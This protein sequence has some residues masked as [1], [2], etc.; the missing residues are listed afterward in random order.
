MKGME[1]I[2]KMEG[3]TIKN[4]MTKSLKNLV[5][6]RDMVNNHL[7][8]QITTKKNIFIM[9]IIIKMNTT[10]IHKKESSKNMKCFL[11]IE[12]ITMSRLL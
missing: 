12:E 1:L 6:I 8:M 5:T 9:I 11:Q 3:T 10:Q 2:I 4:I 7:V